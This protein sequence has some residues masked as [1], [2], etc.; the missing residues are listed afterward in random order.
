MTRNTKLLFSIMMTV[1]LLFG[2]MFHFFPG[3]HFE[4]LHIFLFNLC[5][6]GTIVL[7]FTEGLGEP[8]GKVK[9]FFA[10]SFIYAILSSFELYA[11]AIVVSLCMIPIVEYI[12]IKKFSLFPSDFFTTKVPTAVKFHQAS[13]LCLSMGLLISAFAIVNEEY[14]RVLDFEKLTLNTFFLGFSFP[15]SLITFSL[16]FTLMHKGRTPFKRFLKLMS[17]WVINLGVIIFFVFILME[18]VVLELVVSS[19][20]FI[21]VCNVLIMYVTLGMKE[22]QKTFLTSGIFFLMVTAVTGIVYIMLYSLDLNSP[23]NKALVLNYHRIAA[24]YGWNLSGLAVICRFNDFPI[25]LH[26]GKTILLHW[27]IVMLLAPLGY[28]Y[29]S[30]GIAAVIGYAFFLRSLFFSTGTEHIPSFERNPS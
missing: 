21:A 15:L 28:Y 11:P 17:F 13:L 3:H 10:L 14:V 16:I 26:S 30:A 2:Y 4:R 19:V 27:I 20:L 18:S 22:Q 23:E 24:L 29:V 25:R 8:S 7:Y 9:A 1:A 6:G 12:R 5:T